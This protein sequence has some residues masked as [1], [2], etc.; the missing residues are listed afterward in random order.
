MSC[1]H[2][3]SYDK[4]YSLNEPAT[5]K[6]KYELQRY[7]GTILCIELNWFRMNYNQQL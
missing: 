3:E 7:R 4:M 1:N 5:L 6:Q 2:G